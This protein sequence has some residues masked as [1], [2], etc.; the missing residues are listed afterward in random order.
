MNKNVR[1]ATGP[2]GDIHIFAPIFLLSNFLKPSS[3]HSSSHH[4]F[5]LGGSH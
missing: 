1:R 2:L 3:R 5:R 4:Q